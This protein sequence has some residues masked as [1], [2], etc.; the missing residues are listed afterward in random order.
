MSS[1][2]PAAQAAEFR[3]GASRRAWPPGRPGQSGFT[4]IELVISAGLM[5]LV[6]VSAYLCMHAASREPKTD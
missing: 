5:S 2:A 1:P 3:F 6:L 4:L